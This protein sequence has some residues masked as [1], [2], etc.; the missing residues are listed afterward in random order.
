MRAK[1]L[2][3]RKGVQYQEIDVSSDDQKRHWLVQTT[4]QRTVPQ[5]FINDK[6]VGGFDEIAALDRK[7]E[8]DPMLAQ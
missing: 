1:A 5:I 8:L 4:G 6:S 2:F 3:A 7:G